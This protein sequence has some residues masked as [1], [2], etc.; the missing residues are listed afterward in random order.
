MEQVFSIPGL[1]FLLITSITSRDYMMV[2]TIVIY[3]AFVVILINTLVDIAI[4][5]IDPRI[6]LGIGHE[7][8]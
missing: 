4:Q 5:V 3:I 2:G 6:R 8:N 1:G 7:K